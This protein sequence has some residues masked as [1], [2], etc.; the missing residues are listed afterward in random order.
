MGHNPLGTLRR[1]LSKWQW[2]IREVEMTEDSD[3]YSAGWCGYCGNG[4]GGYGEDQLICEW[5]YNPH[6]ENK[7]YMIKAIRPTK[8]LGFACKTAGDEP[9]WVLVNGREVIKVDGDWNSQ[10]RRG[11]SEPHRFRHFAGL[12]PDGTRPIPV[13]QIGETRP[14]NCDGFRFIQYA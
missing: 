10:A 5:V 8:N 1:L 13:E 2:T 4:K 6:T 9:R 3:A 11:S 7:V 14:W 12:I